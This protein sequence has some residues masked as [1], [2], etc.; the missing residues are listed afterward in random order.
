[1][2]G[3]EAKLSDVPGFYTHPLF[4][5]D[6]KTVIA[7]RSS[8]NARMHSYME[9]GAT[10]T[11]ELVALL[12]GTKHSMTLAKGQ[13]GGT[14]HFGTDVSSVYVNFND[15]VYAVPLSGGDKTRVASISGPGWYFAEGRAQA[16]DI[17]ISPDGREALVQIAQQLYLVE[18]PEPGRSID[19]ADADLRHRKLTDVGADFFGWSDEGNT[20][21]W[22]IGS[23]WY[24]RARSGIRLA[25]GSAGD[26]PDV[27]GE[28]FA[29]NI[30]FPRA[31]EAT[32]NIVLRGGTALTM[33]GDE[34]I[35]DA[36]IIVSDGRIAAIGPRGTLALPEGATI[37]DISGKWVV[38]GFIDT[39]DHIADVR[40]QL[41]D[42]ESWGPLANLAYGVTTAFD[43]STLTI[44]MLAYQDAIDAGLMVG[45]RIRSTGPAIFS[46]NEFESYDQVVA[47]LKRYR[48]DYRLHNI[49]MYRSGNRRVRQWIAEAAREV[50]LQPTTE[51]ALA[52]KLDLSQMIDGYAGK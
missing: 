20:V 1:M 22:A 15:G 48:D 46:F 17:R 36:D 42:F 4:A 50:G 29:A 21:G 18:L 10:R 6:G 52:M 13:I 25:S 7:V 43:P 24:R 8:N 2:S 39:H 49:K 26:S 23:T 11:A 38:P 9:Y 34:Q 19:L 32:G 37:R 31:I 33:N 30:E 5:P 40:R 3:S 16:D 41:L 12:A 45:S 14:P 27:A 47:V 44:D 51:G 28:N 35:S